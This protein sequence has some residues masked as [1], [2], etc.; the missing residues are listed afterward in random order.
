MDAVVG[1]QT[2]TEVQVVDASHP[3]IIRAEKLRANNGELPAGRILAK[4]ANGDLVS[5]DDGG[6]APVNVPVGILTRGVD[7]AKDAVGAVLRHG[8]AV[9]SSLTKA[10]GA[11]PTAAD[12]VKLE[13][14]IFAS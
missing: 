2:F 8:I 14:F 5:Y 6:V 1:K 9:K 10:A 3:A 13:P 12:L 11:A 4:D 7:T